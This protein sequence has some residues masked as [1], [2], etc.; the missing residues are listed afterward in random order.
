MT[1]STPTHVPLRAAIIGAGGIATTHATAY[2]AAGVDLVAVCDVD[3]ALARK[4]ADAWGVER[5]YDDVAA[6][7]REETLDMVSVCTPASTHHAITLQAAGAGVHVLCEKPI[8]VDLNEAQ[9]MIDACDAAG[10]VLQVG[11]QLRSHPAIVQAKTMID[12]GV[13]GEVT[14]VRLRQ[15][16]D[17]GGASEVR[18]SFATRASGGGG[19]LLDNGCHLMDLARYLA[20]DVE[21]VYGRVATR[22]WPIELEDS[23]IVSLRFRS[24][25]L[26]SV[27]TSW[28]ATGWEEGFWVYG[29]DGSLEWTNRHAD[30]VL[31]HAS[32]TSGSTDWSETDVTRYAFT[33]LRGHD[34]EIRAFVRAVREGAPVP[35]TGED[36]LEAVRLVLAGYDSA[37]RNAPLTLGDEASNLARAVEGIEAGNAS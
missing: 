32:R 28:S 11:H 22:K 31:V 27:E 36:G 12:E 8:A 37:S 13:I 19:T 16:H 25:A 29:T 17:W 18:P 21:E 10:V 2:Q 30:P 34:A 23:A 24:G 4:R 1:P 15:A 7:L 33:E 26:G 20:G 6:L 35:C 5:V 9:A 3:A 14:M